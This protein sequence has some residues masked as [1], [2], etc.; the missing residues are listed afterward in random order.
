MAARQSHPLPK[1]LPEPL[2]SWELP[3][4]AMAAGDELPWP[5]LAA[6]TAAARGFLDPPLLGHG[7][8]WEPQQ[9]RWV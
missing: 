7:V 3:Y 8:R 5:T 6:V 9:W 1:M 4:A 2:S